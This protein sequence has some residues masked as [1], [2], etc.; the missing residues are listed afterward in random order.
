MKTPEHIAKHRRKA[1]I[2]R[3]PFRVKI[4]TTCLAELEQCAIPE[5]IAILLVGRTVWALRTEYGSV[6]GFPQFNKSMWG[7]T[8]WCIPEGTFKR[9]K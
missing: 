4:K 3:R 9:I 6:L 8:P 2:K 7:Q 5:E 1:G